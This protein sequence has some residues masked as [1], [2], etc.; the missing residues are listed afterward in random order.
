MSHDAGCP[1]HP[2]HIDAFPTLVFPMLRPPHPLA[3]PPH[4]AAPHHLFTFPTAVACGAGRLSRPHA[5]GKRPPHSL[6][7]SSFDPRFAA[8]VLGGVS[9]DA[10]RPPAEPIQ[11]GNLHTVPRA[12]CTWARSTGW[13]LQPH[14]LRLCVAVGAAAGRATHVRPRRLPPPRRYHGV[15]ALVVAHGVARCAVRPRRSGAAPLLGA[16]WRACYGGTPAAAS[17]G[18]AARRAGRR[19]TQRDW[20]A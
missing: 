1:H 2:K 16:Y 8:A 17:R 6:T 19:A 18:P 4:T 10:R 5:S 9:T 12:R 7:S 20:P 3:R 15:A 13:R 11:R 14:R